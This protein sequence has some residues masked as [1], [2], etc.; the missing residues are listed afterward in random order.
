MSSQRIYDAWGWNNPV[1]LK[2]TQA[3]VE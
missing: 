3:S 2:I 1:V